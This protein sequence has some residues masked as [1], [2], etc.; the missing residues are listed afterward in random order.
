MTNWKKE[1]QT[2]IKRYAASKTLVEL[3][4]RF[5]RPEEEVEAKLLEMK[6]ASKDGH[7]YKARFI[8]PSVEHYEKGLEPFHSGRW[9][10]AKKHFEKVV[11]QS[12]QNDLAARAR[13]FIGICEEDLAGPGD[14]GD[15]F[16]EAGVAWGAQLLADL[17]GQ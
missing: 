13:V 12:E 17:D 15:P 7:G 6:T 14:A 11:A 2:Y 4:E 3:A 5:G 8:D 1:E 16:L 9:S 10:E